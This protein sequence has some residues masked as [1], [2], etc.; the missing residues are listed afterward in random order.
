MPELDNT[1]SLHLPTGPWTG[2][3]IEDH[4]PN[5][6]WMHLYLEFSDGEIRGEGTDY[7]GPWHISGTYSEAA[8]SC[9]WTKRY[10]GKHT[11]E[12]AGQTGENGILGNWKI[13][14]WSSG[15]FH[16]WPSDRTDLQEM[17][18]KDDQRGDST[19]IQLGTRGDQ[20]PIL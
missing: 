11:V 19:T 8:A 14:K 20:G 12:Y 3:Y 10:V 13:K 6:S 5:R 9:Q 4:K 2:F 7:V 1:S 18:M 15:P 17:Y 16:I